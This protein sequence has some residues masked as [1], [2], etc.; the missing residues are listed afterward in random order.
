MV[1]MEGKGVVM[2]EGGKGTDHEV[3]GEVI[4]DGDVGEEED[5]VVEL[6]EVDE[7]CEEVVV[8]WDGVGEHLVVD[9][10]QTLDGRAVFQQDEEG[11]DFGVHFVG[12][13]VWREGEREMKWENSW[14]YRWRIL[15]NVK[16]VS[17]ILYCIIG[18]F[19]W[20]LVNLYPLKFKNYSI[21]YNFGGKKRWKRP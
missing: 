5:G 11:W 1:V 21:E 15:G 7:L 16:G 14:C 17:V 20:L 18:F 9:F 10:H 6:A 4:G 3:E 2:V 19:L 8:A 12:M 13:R